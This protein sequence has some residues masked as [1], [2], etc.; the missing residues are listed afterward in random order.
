MSMITTLSA[1][2]LLVLLAVQWYRGAWSGRSAPHPPGPPG[3]FLIGNL[4]QM[5]S[6]Y[7]WHTF[8]EWARKYGPVTYLN[9][10]GKP[11][12]VI[13]TQEAAIDLL[14]K[15]AAIYSDRPRMVMI[16]LSGFAGSTAFLRM[17][18]QHRKHR[19]ILAQALH[20]RVVERDYVP[21]QERIARQ[22]A[23][24]LLDSP[25]DYV[26][27][28]HRAMGESV[29]L[30]AYGDISDGKVDLLQLGKQNMLNVGKIVTGYAVDLITWL[31][32]LPEWFPGAQF[33]RDANSIRVVTHKTQWLPYNMV[34]SRAALGTAPPSFTL[35]GLETMA[36]ST[37]GDL[38]DEI[39]SSTAMTL[40]GA[41]SDTIAG[42]LCTFMLAMLLY[43]EVQAKARAE[44]DRVVG[45]DRLP[46]CASRDSTP[47]LNAVL[48]ETLRWH[49]VMPT[50]IPHRLVQDDI[51]EGHLIPAGTTVFVNAWGILHDERRFPDPMTFNPDRY[52]NSTTNDKDGVLDPWEVGFG[53][54]RRICQGI[55]VVRSGLWIAVATILSS[56][57]I[58][59]K[60]DPATKEPI[61]PEAKWTGTVTS[62]P[63]PFVCDI[64]PRSPGY[65]D[66]IR[67]AV[68]EDERVMK[69]ETS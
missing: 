36:A 47:Y 27:H 45:E 66:R 25:A 4:R 56:F 34:K 68:A 17:G 51:Y 43:P 31:E 10:A 40:F 9:V 6:S 35:T 33:K 18:P 8:A 24:S 13:N 15:R 5:P 19:K 3:D 50:G 2:A 12:L 37:D 23:K 64:I 46:T 11:I 62:F 55:P 48:L 67:E 44:I 21:L 38:D 1:I 14:E 42:T 39:I 26:A 22:F 54:G 52:L 7:H 29:Q 53:Y 28:I 41:G 32:Y 30:I 60:I 65:A 59:P 69:V 16:E 20:P 61:V 49:N 57:D 58:R 63:L